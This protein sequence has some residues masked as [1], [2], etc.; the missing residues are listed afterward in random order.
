M[1]GLANCSLIYNLRPF[2][3]RSLLSQSSRRRLHFPASLAIKC[4][5]EA[6]SSPTDVSGSVASHFR[7]SSLGGNH[8]PCNFFYAFLL[9]GMWPHI[10]LDDR[11][12]S[13]GQGATRWKEPGSLSDCGVETPARPGLL[14]FLCTVMRQGNKLLSC[15]SRCV[16]GTSVYSS[17]ARMP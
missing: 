13:C 11:R 6:T 15:W 1:A 5:H 2:Y 14:A 10:A 9:V 4:G 12:P 3:N 7:S 16:L 17:F 8:L